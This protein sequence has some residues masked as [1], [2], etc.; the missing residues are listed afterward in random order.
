MR[1]GDSLLIS[2]D[3]CAAHLGVSR[4]TITRLV[5]G[6]EWLG[7]RKAGERYIISRA[8]FERH[9]LDGIVAEAETERH[10]FL[11]RIDLAS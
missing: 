6:G 4:N 5:M 8:A 1:T 11:R 7:A 2:V 9:Y 3:D 10:P